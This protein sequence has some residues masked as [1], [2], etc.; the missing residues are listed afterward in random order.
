LIFATTQVGDL[1]A[2]FR[3]TLTRGKSVI[4]SNHG[5]GIVGARLVGEEEG[6]FVSQDACVAVGGLGGGMVVEGKVVFC[7]GAF[8]NGVGKVAQ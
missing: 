3:R 6:M 1:G 5:E 2:Q 7:V 4:A 8:C